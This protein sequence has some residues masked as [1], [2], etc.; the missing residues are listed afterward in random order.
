MKKLVSSNQSGFVKES[1]IT[2][3]I[4]LA[5]E[6]IHNISKTNKSGN[7]VI[8]LDMSQAY[9]RMSWHFVILVLSKFGFSKPFTKLILI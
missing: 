3:S 5:Q 4:L 7:I 9:D 6:I 2:E 1:L 8:K